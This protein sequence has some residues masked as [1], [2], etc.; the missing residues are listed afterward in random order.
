MAN[1]EKSRK[2]YKR[3]WYQANKDKQKLYNL[4]TAARKIQQLQEQGVWIDAV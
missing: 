1:E 3:K 4:R 2:E